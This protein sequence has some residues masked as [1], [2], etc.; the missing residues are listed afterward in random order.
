MLVITPLIVTVES[1]MNSAVSEWCAAA[2]TANTV[3]DKATRAANFILIGISAYAPRLSSNGLSGASPVTGV[4]QL[5]YC[6]LRQLFGRIALGRDNGA[7]S[8]DLR[9]THR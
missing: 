8:S 5:M 1:G 6:H 3:T 7:P 9:K 4:Y 2:G